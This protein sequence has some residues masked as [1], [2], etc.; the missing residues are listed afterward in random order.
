MDNITFLKT[1]LLFMLLLLSLISQAGGS[2]HPVTITT[3]SSENDKFEFTADVATHRSWIDKECHKIQVYGDYD[4]N[5]WSSYKRPMSID[6]HMR[7][8]TYLAI[9]A[10]ANHQVLFGYMGKG[11][12]KTKSCTYIS[13]GLIYSYHDK[14]I[15]MWIHDSI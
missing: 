9:S 15:I 6:N 14:V 10:K 2:Y 7:A 13:K 12:H 5:R 3:F 8:I 1:L 4:A 11:L